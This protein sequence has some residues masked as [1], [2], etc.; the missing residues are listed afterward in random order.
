[1]DIRKDLHP[2]NIGPN[3]VFLPHAGFSLSLKEKDIFY[4]VLK[5]VKVP[6]SYGSN[7]CWTK[8]S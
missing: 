7:V 3:K 2:I 1:M 4:H 6:K 8:K 5:E